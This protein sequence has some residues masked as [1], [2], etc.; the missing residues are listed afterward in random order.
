MGVYLS[1][2]GF[3]SPMVHSLHQWLVYTEG[4]RGACSLWGWVKWGSYQLILQAEPQSHHPGCRWDR[5]L[6]NQ[7]KGPW[8]A[9]TSAWR[10]VSLPWAWRW[11]KGVA[12]GR[13]PLRMSLGVSKQRTTRSPNACAMEEVSTE[14]IWIKSK[15]CILKCQIMITANPGNIQAWTTQLQDKR[16][17]KP[18]QL[19]NIFRGKPIIIWEKIWFKKEVW[20]SGTCL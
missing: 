2:S 11:P 15:D 3:P 18:N 16:S 1:P 10:W 12:M 14:V 19:E 9:P 6:L 20:C 5:H 7:G 13:G 8:E 17:C 4:L